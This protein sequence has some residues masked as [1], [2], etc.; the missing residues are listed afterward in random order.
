M[1]G[2]LQRDAA[3]RGRCGQ[4]LLGLRIDLRPE[5]VESG[6]RHSNDAGELMRM[7]SMK[8]VLWIMLSLLAIAAA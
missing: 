4:L 1:K 7:G 6:Q 8:Y 5:T 3:E 2:Y